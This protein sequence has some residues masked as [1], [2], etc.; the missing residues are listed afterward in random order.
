M[1]MARDRSPTGRAL[2]GIKEEL[3]REG[4]ATR[5]QLAEAEQVALA[6]GKTLNQALAD[7]D[8]VNDEDLAKFLGKKLHIPYV[9]LRNYTIDRQLLKKVPEKKA[10][11][12]RVLPLFLL[13]GELTIAMADPLDLSTLD[14][15]RQMVGSNIAPV[16]AAPGSVDTAIEQWYG[17]GVARQ[18][19]IGQLAEEFEV[20]SVAEEPGYGNEM[21]QIRLRQE[22]NEAPIIKL[23]NT[24]I[25]QAMLEEAT[26]VHIEPRP[27]AVV[28]RFRID[29]IMYERHKA[30][31]ALIPAIVSRVKIMS[32]LDITKRRI[33]QDGRMGL[34]IRDRRLDIRVST[35]PSMH[36]ENIVLRL[37]EP[38]R[39]MASVSQ[40]G[41]TAVDARSFKAALAATRG[42]ILATGPT[43]SGKTT[44]MYAA[45]SSLNNG[46]RSIFSIEDPIE[47]EMEGVVQSQVDKAGGVTFAS[48]L[49]AFL[50]QDPDVIYV[51]EIRDLETATIAAQA[52]MTGHIVLTTLHTN[53]AL[54]SVSRLMDLGVDPSTL[55]N[56][57]VCAFAQRLVRKVCDQCAVAY[58]PAL[59]VVARYQLREGSE[60]VRAVGCEMCHGIGY[61]GRMGIFEVVRFDTE[62]GAL[63]AKRADANTLAKAARKQGMKSLFENGL[64]KVLA[65]ETTLEE[66]LRVVED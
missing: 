50:R 44:T 64:D 66:L 57:L 61:S 51:G 2:D 21:Q 35:L 38:N 4:I 29:G 28:I 16:I 1:A 8:I 52:A 56:V 53:D 37:L 36:G 10:R 62:L 9:N 25:I 46:E 47:Y 48:A 11:Y 55:E 31:A 49:R 17:M 5:A 43:G 60:L 59:D 30:P 58:K 12:Y 41:M 63:I 33:P 24:Y 32:G 65:R 54:G 18:E 26:D 19:L 20:E 7:L 3:I 22:A 27:D 15:I 13:E 6:H 34:L 45:L 23:V 40:L 42:V 14:E 39:R